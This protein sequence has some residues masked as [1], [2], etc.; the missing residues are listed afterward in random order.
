MKKKVRQIEKILPRIQELVQSCRLCGN[1]CEIDRA[2]KT[3][4]CRAPAGASDRLRHS[5]YTL[6]FGEEPM[7]VGQ[8]GSGTVFFTHCNLRCVFCQNC[9]IS[10]FGMGDEI[11]ANELAQIFL[12]LQS[13]GARN[14]NLVTPTHYIHPILLALREA[15]DTGLNLPL[16]YNTN[17]F[18]HVELVRVLDGIVDIYLP[19]MKYMDA[20]RSKK[21][22]G[23]AAYPSTAKESIREMWR[24]VGAVKWEGETAASGLIIRHLI[25]PEDLANTYDFLFW[26]KDEDMT[27]ATIS[28][29]S[30]YSPQ[31]R[32]MEY[33]ELRAA[34]SRREYA[35]IVRFALDRGFENLLVQG[36]DS[37]EVYLPDFRRNDPFD[38]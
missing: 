5:S 10:Q 24:Q 28:L 9:Q 20:E 27:G 3:G 11:G 26:L 30:Q 29:M 2:Q 25:L 4:L 34:I 16:V 32:A 18:D 19:D 1:R 6:H 13:I 38:R 14:I 36:L 35:D 33:P 22:S 8:G 23:A 31:H 15:Y 37:R 21:Y 7:L 17:G 12:H